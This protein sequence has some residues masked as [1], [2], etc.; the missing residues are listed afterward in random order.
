[1]QIKALEHKKHLY[2]YAYAIDKAIADDPT[3]GGIADRVA[4]VQ[5]RYSQKDIGAWEIVITLRITMETMNKE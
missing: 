3:F 5:K 2:F 1:M 4:I